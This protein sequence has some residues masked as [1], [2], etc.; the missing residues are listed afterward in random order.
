FPFTRL[1]IRMDVPA[2]GTYT[3][4]H[5]YGQE[6]FNVEAIGPGHEIRMSRDIEMIGFNTL[7]NG[8]VGPVLVAIDPL[9]PTGFVGDINVDQRVTGSPCG[10]NFFR[11]IGPPG[12]DLG[13]GPGVPVETDLFAVQGKLFSGVLP[14][15]LEVNR[16]TYSRTSTTGQIDVF[17]TSAPTA[18][19][20]VSGSPG[21]PSGEIFLIGDGSGKFYKNI[22]VDNPSTLPSFVTVTA[23]RAGESPT[24]INSNLVDLVTITKAEYN[25][26]NSTLTVEANSSD[27]L[28]PPTLTL[29]GYGNLTSGQ[30]V[31]NNVSVSPATVTVTSSA[32]GSATLP[33]TII[34]FAQATYSISGTITFAPAN[35]GGPASGV[36]VILTSGSLTRVT[37]TDANGVYIF[38]GLSDGSYT[39]TPNRSGYAFTPTNLTVNISGGDLT[40]QN[41]TA[42]LLN[43][44]SISGTITSGGAPIEGVTVT[45]TGSVNAET[46][47]NALGA[48]IF[49]NLPNGTYTI[50]PSHPNYNFAPI[51]RTITIN[52]ANVIGQVFVGTFITRS[53]TG[54][55]STATGPLAGVAVYLTGPINRTVST[56]A[57]GVYSFTGLVNGDYVVTPVLTGY[58]FTPTTANVRV[59][60]ADVT[61]INF[62]AVNRVFN[63]SG[64]VVNQNGAGVANV[65]VTLT[66]TGVIRTARTNIF[67][68]FT[69]TGVSNGTYVIAPDPQPG[70]VFDPVNRNVT[71]NNGNVTGIRFRRLPAN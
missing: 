69:I 47:T 59:N 8:A 13:N 32:G 57:S 10:T 42:S 58:S 38:T 11:V 18:I 64:R 63:V 3:V 45:L 41:F 50:T 67:G 44:F 36:T 15:Q 29:V 28:V 6:T 7:H 39:I 68:N 48:Y 40:G 27:R 51:N 9:P 65:T 55:I 24:S 46:T 60:N 33:V 43:I 1:R 66:G 5:P 37:S 30:I 71:V 62:T 49:N 56:N 25:V 35:G 52:G 16:T 22:I 61:G 31:V 14:T 54:T 17:A 21:L 19:L 12:V 26:E 53:I 4:I 2:P 70:F 20:S 23:S 34:P